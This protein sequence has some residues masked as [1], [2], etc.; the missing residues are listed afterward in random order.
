MD[1]CAGGELPQRVLV[2][3]CLLGHLVRYNGS[4]LNA[5]N[6]ILDKWLKEGR[7][8]P[9]CP[10]VTAGLGI[11]REPAEICNENG[12]AVLSGSAKVVA[13]GGQ[14]LTATSIFDAQQALSLA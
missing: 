11:P 9:I 12:F 14:D 3:S 6:S 2:S 8:I 10:E 4:A 13:E 7:L 1:F 5:D